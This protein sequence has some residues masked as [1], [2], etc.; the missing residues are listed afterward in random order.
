MASSS[1]HRDPRTIITPDAFEVSDDLIGTPLALPRRRAA[2]LLIDGAMVVLIT[3]LTKS[4]ALI[5]GV[6]AAV[7]FVRAGFKRTPVKGSVFGRAMRFSVGC[8]GL[9]I[10]MI[11]AALWSAFGFDFGGGFDGATITAF[12]D[13]GPTVTAPLGAGNVAQQLLGALGTAGLVRLFEE[14]ETLEEAEETVMGV[15]EA[16]ESLGLDQ[17]EL[18]SLLFASVPDDASWSEDAPALLNRLL[19]ESDVSQ[20]D[21]EIVASLEEE[22]SGYTTQELLTEYASLLAAAR[23]DPSTDTRRAV[24]GAHL[25]RRVAGDTLRAYQSRIDDLQDEVAG[26][27]RALDAANEELDDARGLV[28]WIRDRFDDLGFGFGWAALYMTVFLSWW[29]GQT[30]GKRAMGIRVVRLDGEPITWWVAF[31]R[32]GGYAAGFATGLLGFAQVWWD[33]NRQA[34]HD[35]IVGTVVVVEGAEKVLDWESAL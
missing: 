33:A 2:A 32:S 8:L 9:V 11:T 17:G 12:V 1:V 4:F 24:L 31:E 7:F 14:A 25:G 3:L 35:R 26:Q 27:R 28:G 30:I 15:I 16:S 34:I 10:A 5:L 13:D 19:P 6:A 29:N 22:V 18:R 23:G 21:L 20:A